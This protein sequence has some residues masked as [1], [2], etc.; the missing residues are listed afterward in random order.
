MSSSLHIFQHWF[1]EQKA[2]IHVCGLKF[3]GARLL[4]LFWSTADA[5]VNPKAVAT[6]LPNIKD[7]EKGAEVFSIMSKTLHDDKQAF[8]FLCPIQ[9]SNASTGHEQ[10]GVVLS[11]IQQSAVEH[12]ASAAVARMCPCSQGLGCVYALPCHVVLC[13]ANLYCVMWCCAA[14]CNAPPCVCHVVSCGVML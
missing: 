9:V 1:L 14:L 13:C 5:K 11:S 7:R 10:G 8:E 4:L 3:F 12:D 6:L 2:T